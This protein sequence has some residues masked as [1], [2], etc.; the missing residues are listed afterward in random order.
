MLDDSAR[1]RERAKQCRE[2]ASRAR[3][4]F[5]RGQLSQMAT[6]L[7]EEA[8]KIEAEEA[9]DLDG[10]IARIRFNRASLETAGFVGW[11]PFPAIRTTACPTCGGIYVVLY[12]GENPRSFADRSCGGWFKGKDPTVPHEALAANWVDGVEVVYIG[13]ADQLKRRLTQYADFG[14]GKPVGHWGGRL[15]WQLPNADA[16]LVAWKETPNRVPAEVEA[17]LITAFRQA[18]GKPP[19]A[20]DPHRLGA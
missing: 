20:N 2:L 16:L 9:Q 13:K 5:S 11:V 15:I 19:F 1:F 17:E 14:E 10:A 18:H 4:E 6:E 8:D 7:D 12:S 3:D